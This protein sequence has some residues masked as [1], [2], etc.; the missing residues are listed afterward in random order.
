MG[1]RYIITGFRTIR[2]FLKNICSL[3]ARKDYDCMKFNSK[4]QSGV[5][6]TAHLEHW[7]G[8]ISNRIPQR[9][10]VIN[11]GT[12]EAGV[13]AGRDL[14]DFMGSLAFMDFEHYRV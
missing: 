12:K 4:L 2:C 9:K 6:T 8:S 13:C 1:R 3:N 14:S 7:E 5:K 11:L 10:Q